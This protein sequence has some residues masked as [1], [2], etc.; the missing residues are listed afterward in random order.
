M[1]KNQTAKEMEPK[2]L[3]RVDLSEVYFTRLQP[4]QDLFVGIAE[5]CKKNNIDRAVIH[6][7]T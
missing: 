5:F 4:G 6:S 1:V 2:F 7:A 3:E